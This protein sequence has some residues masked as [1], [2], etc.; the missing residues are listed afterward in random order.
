M[1]KGN[2]KMDQQQ[3]SAL[4]APARSAPRRRRRP[5]GQ[6]RASAALAERRRELEPPRQQLREARERE[7]ATAEVLK[8]ISRSAFDL[9]GVFDTLINSAGRLCRADQ[10]SLD[11]I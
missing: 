6:S 8:V 9:Q 7:T 10:A 2:D 1:V 5:R 3:I 4:A 11:L